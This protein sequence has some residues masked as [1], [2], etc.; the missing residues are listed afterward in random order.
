[1]Y[2]QFKAKSLDENQWWA[3]VELLCVFLDR[4]DVEAYRKRKAAIMKEVTYLRKPEKKK[5]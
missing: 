2:E 5:K 3:L 1:M 4:N